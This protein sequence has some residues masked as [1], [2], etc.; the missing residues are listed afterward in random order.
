MSFIRPSELSQIEQRRAFEQIVKCL[1][2]LEARIAA[3]EGPAA[4]I[5]GLVEE[6]ESIRRG[7]DAQVGYLLTEDGDTIWAED[8][9]GP[10]GAEIGTP[11][12]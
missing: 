5:G 1:S 12:V 11:L 10:L 4:L 7:I 3:I 9:S 6:V 8:L 2:A